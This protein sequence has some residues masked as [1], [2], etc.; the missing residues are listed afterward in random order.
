[1]IHVYINQIYIYTIE[2]DTVATAT[3]TAATEATPFVYADHANR[4]KI[5]KL[6][7]PYIH[8]TYSVTTA[9]FRILSR[10]DELLYSPETRMAIRHCLTD[11]TD[12][13][14]HT[15][16]ESPHSTRA[17]LYHFCVKGSN[18]IPL[19]LYY[20][21]QRHVLPDLVHSANNI[22][23]SDWDS[24]ILINP[25][26]TE[27]QFTCIFETLVPIVQ[28]ELVEIS[29][30]IPSL[31][32]MHDIKNAV[33]AVKRFVDAVP[34]YSEFRKYPITFKDAKSQP[35]KIHDMSSKRPEVKDFVSRLGPAG[36]GL[37]VSSTRTGGIGPD[38][39]GHVPP[40]FF[41][42]RILAF[43]VASRDIRLP[44]E[45]FD[46][47]MN[48]QNEDL[49]FSWESYSEYHIRLPLYSADFRVISPVGL[50][51]DLVKC[52]YD[53]D[54]SNN[55]T[56]K[57]KMPSRIARIQRVLDEMIIPYRNTNDAILGNIRRHSDSRTLVGSIVRRMNF[58]R[59]ATR[60]LATNYYEEK[61]PD[62]SAAA[63]T[64]TTP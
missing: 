48:Y 14:L 35:L 37:F 10:F 52:I 43:V 63:E 33:V 60:T 19:L 36:A 3:A 47:S 22:Y 38:E 34:E 54:R 55:A 42:G 1:V 16:L 21:Q 12:S 7:H 53:A 59:R 27:R 62:A 30:T 17:H 44:V 41:L 31:A 8:G 51:T 18:C 46:I 29:K 24:T 20:L 58:T 32:L 64:A 50:Y 5:A 26:L 49:H 15:L 25:M 28:S 23:E 4:L 56:R 6:I 61:E 39:E 11:S 45:M 13:N 9:C 40:K 2:M 57:N